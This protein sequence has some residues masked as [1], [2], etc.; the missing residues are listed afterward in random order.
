MSHNID[1]VTKFLA[2]VNEG[3]PVIITRQ[4]FRE[5]TT[6]TIMDFCQMYQLH[7]ERV[8]MNNRPYLYFKQIT[9]SPSLRRP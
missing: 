5:M 3:E 7:C 9:E 4:I 2:E 6:Q 8:Q 1:R